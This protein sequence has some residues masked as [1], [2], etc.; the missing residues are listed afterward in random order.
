MFPLL[1]LIFSLIALSQKK[2]NPEQGGRDIEI[3]GLV[4]SIILLVLTILIAISVLSYFGV[5]SPRVHRP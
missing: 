2:K 3:V 1:G 5:F 4:I